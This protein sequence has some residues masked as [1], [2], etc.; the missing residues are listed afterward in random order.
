[1]EVLCGVVAFGYYQEF[2]YKMVKYAKMLQCVLDARMDTAIRFSD[3]VSLLKR[4]GFNLRI[5]G[6]HHIFSCEG[7]EEIINIQPKGA[8]VKAYQVKQIREI[9]LRYKIGIE[10]DE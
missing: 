6:D 5:R 1:M 9:L 8:M 4:L 10:T 2:I 7:I 3:V